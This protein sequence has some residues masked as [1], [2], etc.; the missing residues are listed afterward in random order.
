MN[1]SQFFKD[2]TGQYSATRLAFLIWAAGVFLVWAYMCILTKSLV[3]IPQTVVE[4]TGLFMGGKVIQSHI[5]NQPTKP[6]E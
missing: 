4:V 6:N 5:E 2:D 1:L 3:E